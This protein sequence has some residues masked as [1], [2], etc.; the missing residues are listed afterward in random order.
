MLL[1]PSK[2][3]CATAHIAFVD[4]GPHKHLPSGRA[5][6]ALPCERSLNNNSRSVCKLAHWAHD[7][8]GRRLTLATISTIRAKL[9]TLLIS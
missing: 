2:L 3:V 4:I 8:G 6:L 1:Y 7:A 5:G 9:F